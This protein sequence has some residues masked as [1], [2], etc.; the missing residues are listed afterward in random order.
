MNKEKAFLPKLNWITGILIQ[1]KN[2]K[3]LNRLSKSRAVGS[4]YKNKKILANF[5]ETEQEI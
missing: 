3:R 2:G 1:G 5:S 4:W